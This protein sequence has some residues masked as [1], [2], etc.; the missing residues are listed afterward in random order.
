MSALKQA[1]DLIVGFPK[2]NCPPP[3][4][5]ELETERRFSDQTLHDALKFLG[6]LRQLTAY[7]RELW[8]YWIME[9][10][11]KNVFHV[12]VTKRKVKEGE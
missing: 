7:T 8:G 3:Y 5:D 9:S 1:Y 6:N 4:D 12:A 11:D 10:K 2:H